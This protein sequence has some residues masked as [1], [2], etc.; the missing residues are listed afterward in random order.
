M[1]WT[2]DILSNWESAIIIG[3]LLAYTLAFDAMPWFDCY[4]S[5]ELLDR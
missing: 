5:W 3:P 4:G 1:E 2:A